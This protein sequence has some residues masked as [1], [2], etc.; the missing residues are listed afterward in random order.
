PIE[1]DINWAREIVQ[2]DGSSNLSRSKPQCVSLRSSIFGESGPFLHRC[3]RF[4][5]SYS[6]TISIRNDSARNHTTGACARTLYKQ[7]MTSSTCCSP[8]SY[9]HWHSR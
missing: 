2:L 6:L 5:N 9:I 7:C 3:N 4:S 1:K 8:A